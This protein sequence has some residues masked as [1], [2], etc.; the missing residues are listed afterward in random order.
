MLKHGG[1]F[2]SVKCLDENCSSVIG[3]DAYFEDAYVRREILQIITPCLNKDAG[4]E[5]RGEVRN[6]E[7]HNKECTC[8]PVTCSNAGCNENVPLSKL[9]QHQ[10]EECQFRDVVCNSCNMAV[11]WADQAKHMNESCENIHITCGNCGKENIQLCELKRHQDAKD[12]DCTQKECPYRKYGC[13][14][15]VKMDPEEFRAHLGA[16]IV[17]HSLLLLPQQRGASDHRGEATAAELSALRESL[18][19]DEVH[20]A[21]H[22]WALHSHYQMIL[23]LKEDVEK[24]KGVRRKE[25][26]Q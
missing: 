22:D 14:H 23:N 16:S 18:T 24:L 8:R 7:E 1:F 4:C 21:E 11:K 10:E 19:A 26:G 13:E 20:I 6:A 5:W 17:T 12:G 9:A 3:H 2:R 25:D 15:A